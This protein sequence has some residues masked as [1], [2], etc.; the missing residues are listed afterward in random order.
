MNDGKTTSGNMYE[1]F[2]GISGTNLDISHMI[3][4]SGAKIYKKSDDIYD[5]I[6]S[7]LEH[8][9]SEEAFYIVDIG[10]IIRQYLK[11]EE[12][13]PDI[14]PHYAVKSNPNPLILKTLS[15]LGCNFDCA[16][17]NEMA[18]VI[19]I[20]NDPS[21]IIFA[22]P[23][24]MS[25]QIQYARSIDVDLMTFD[26][27][28]ELY[29]IKLY[30]TYS[31]LILRIKVNDAKSVCKFSSKFGATLDEADTLFG[32]AKTLQLNVTGISFHVG[33]GC[34]DLDQYRDAIVDARQYFKLAKDK[35]DM[36]LT[37]LDI[38]GG[39]PG[40]DNDTLRFEDIAQTI[41]TTTREQFADVPNL[42]LIAEPGR[43]LVANSHTLVINVIGKKERVTEEGEKELILYTNEGVYSSFNCIIFDHVIPILKPY[44]ERDGPLYKTTVFGSTCDAFD[45]ITDTIMLP[46]LAIGEWIFT[47]NFGAYTIAAASSFNGFSTGKMEYILTC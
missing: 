14:K 25:N 26:S 20:T 31:D 32:I 36:D 13:M 42:K 27:E 15:A 33:S 7:I 8:N 23:I 10:K 43:F 21:R 22:N 12:F 18:A 39:F 1:F 40:T 46:N 16:S 38:G 3:Q 11:W 41:M 19:A 6:N 5:I 37:V 29:K 24:K 9:M 47:E 34:S 45:R 44:N 28:F 17:K 4:E 2:E 35:F 30:H